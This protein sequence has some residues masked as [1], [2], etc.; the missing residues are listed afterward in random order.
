MR[1]FAAQ[2]AADATVDHGRHRIAAQR[3]GRRLHRQRRAARQPDAGMIA[4]A[5]LVV[6]AV[7]RAGDAHPAFE[8]DGVLGAHAALARQLAFAVGDDHLQAALGG[9]HRL[10]QRLGHQRDRIAAHRAQPFHAH[11]AQRLLDIDAGRRAVAAG[12]ARGNVLLAGGGGVAV[13]HHDQ[14]AVAFVEHV[15]GD[16][17]DQSVMP[18]AAVAHDR[19]R[20]LLH[21]GRDRGGARQRHAVAEN[22]IAERERREGRERM[23][24]DIGADVGRPQFALHQLDG[25][26]H[27]ALRAAGAE[28]GRARRQ[29]PERGCGFGLVRDQ[30]ARLFRHAVG[31]D[32]VRAGRLQERRQAFQQHVGG[33]FAGLAAAAPC[34]ARWSA[35]RRGAVRH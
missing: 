2:A 20:A 32:A 13:L 12:D 35:C 18:E 29:R 15:G 22:G 16:A 17:G 7:A 24:A 10:L 3:I 26:K 1:D 28:G 31:V 21:V 11:D 30:A 8:L 9:L 33:I 14:D 23:A 19:D 27:R 5:D 25:G 4:G 6:D 34:R